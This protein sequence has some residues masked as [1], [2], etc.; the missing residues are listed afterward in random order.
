MNTRERFLAV[1][2]FE[3]VDRTLLWEMGFWAGAVRRWYREGLPRIKG[4]P[5]DLP[6]G[7]SMVGQNMPLDPETLDPIDAPR[8]ET[9]ASRFF[10]LDEPMWRL[11]L[12]NYLCPLFEPKILEDH[13]EWILHQNEY[14]VIVKDQK[15]RNGFPDWV[16]TPVKI[17]DDWERLK[18][19]RLQPTLAG[20]LPAN[21]ENCKKAFRNRTYPLIL[22]GYPA[23]FYG[24]A[25]FLLGEERV[26]LEFYDDPALMHDIMTYLADFWCQLYDQVLQQ[27]D[28]D[29]ILI[30]EDMCYKNGPLISPE[31]F[32]E[33]LL[34]GYLRITGCLRDHGIK[35]VMVDTDGDCW[36]LIPLFLEGGVTALGPFEGNAGMD[37]REVRRAFP[38]LGILG[39][40]DKTKIKLG[41]AAIDAELAKVS[42]L[43]PYGGFVPHMDHQVPPDISWVN[44]QYYRRSLNALIEAGG[45]GRPEKVADKAQIEEQ[46]QPTRSR[47]QPIVR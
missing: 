45:G 8:L 4:V 18:A 5:V 31:M 34:P 42:A 46:P 36:K 22:G 40:L 29:G 27:V 23:G 30:W 17:R 43:L 33:F 44:F 11:P 37:V 3:S 35:V 16:E 38:R 20:R 21:W 2:N 9:D 1:M 47:Y 39:G 15:D 6:D 14:G 19:E 10:D 41:P 32:R 7:R 28:A 13:G 26:M 24:T 12:N 25:R